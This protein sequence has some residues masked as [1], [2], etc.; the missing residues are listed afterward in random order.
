[1]IKKTHRFSFLILPI[2][3]VIDILILLFVLGFYLKLPPVHVVV[4]VVYWF[5]LSFFSQYYGVGRHT[6]YNELL[7]LFFKHVFVFGI[8]ILAYLRLFETEKIS[9]KRLFFSILA[10][11]FLLLLFKTGYYY[12]L[13]LYR[14]HG[15]NLRYFIVFGFNP[16]IKQFK[17]L[18]DQRTDYGYKFIGYFS[19]QKKESNKEILGDFQQGIQFIK[20]NN[21]DVDV[22]FASL[23][24][25]DNKQID[26]LIKVSEE[27]FKHLK[28]I[29]DNKD[30][31]KKKLSVEYFEYYP[32]L[33]IE[34]SPLD[35]PFNS[36]VKRTFDVLFSLMV[37]LFLLSWL[38]PIL[39]II[40]K[41]ESK[42]PVFFKQLRN[43]KNYQPFYC[44]KF[45]SMRPN[46]YADLKQVSENDK[47]VTKV[48]KWLRKTSIDELPQFF[49]VLLGDMSVV[50]PRPHMIAE[51][52]RFRNKVEKF[53]GRH[54]IRPG[55]TGLAQ[56]K[57]FRGEVK[58]DEDILNR[59]KYDLYYIENWS[60]FLDIKII[61]Q[62]VINIFKGDKKAY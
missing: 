19:D 11:F 48:G 6:S 2:A 62:T 46:K 22:I 24:E 10:L 61:L 42:G 52:E 1:M 37:I 35:D 44:Y 23:K 36:F 57:G 29:P 54:Y 9:D 49:N 40:I 38:T 56:V 18:L 33:S 51:N 31:F 27:N 60:I 14:S 3:F 17:K 13:K 12:F 20:T 26:A 41:L 21:G 55:I 32:I 28:F 8:S 58:N 4:L 16:E 50:G 25:L 34:K 7:N 45:R 43:G 30:I 47:R 59:V 15:Y 39:A 5:V 53:L